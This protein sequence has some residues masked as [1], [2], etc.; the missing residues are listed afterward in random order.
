MFQIFITLIFRLTS[1]FSEPAHLARMVSGLPVM[2]FSRYIVGLVCKS[3]ERYRIYVTVIL[4][5]ITKHAPRSQNG[6]N[7]KTSEN[8]QNDPK[9][10]FY[11]CKCVFSIKNS[12]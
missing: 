2:V 10:T 12:P 9:W 7:L 8:D 1:R 11:D 3:V 6:Q 4:W 5:H